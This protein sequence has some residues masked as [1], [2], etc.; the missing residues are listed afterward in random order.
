M[1]TKR[2][3]TLKIAAILLLVLMVV[4]VGMVLVQQYGW[5]TPAGGALNA[6]L[7]RPGQNW[8]ESRP[9]DDR[10]PP[11]RPDLPQDRVFRPGDSQRFPSNGQLSFSLL[12]LRVGRLIR[13]WGGLAL[14]ALAILAAVGVWKGKGWGVTLAILLAALVLLTTLF[15]VFPLRS[16]QLIRMTF[17]LRQ[18]WWL[19]A[20]FGLNVV[21][22]LLA[23]AVLVLLLLP[24]S[25]QAYRASS[26][27]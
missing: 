23:L 1:E 26:P 13:L 7:P 16:L 10:M 2:P 22:I 4:N 20:T 6:R 21:Q 19:L 25:R 9:R 12:W 8:D 24:I 11:S 5:W 17:R 14:L 18:A 3:V 27:S 15:G